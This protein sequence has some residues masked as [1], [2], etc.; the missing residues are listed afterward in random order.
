[1]SS[2]A[3]RLAA[4]R[5]DLV[6]LRRTLHRRPELSEE[7]HG[8]AALLADLLE[9][10]GVDVRTGVGGAGIVGRIRSPR[11]GPVLAL[12]G[13]MDALPIH[14][15]KDAPYR[16]EIDG[17]C[18][19]CGHDVH[20]TAIVGAARL[21][22]ER[23]EELPGDVVVLLQP[24][25]ELSRGARAMI[26][27][28]ALEGVDAILGLHAFPNL[29]AGTVGLRHGPMCAAAESFRI[30]VAGRSGHAARPH[31]GVDAILTASSVVGSI[32]HLVSRRVDPLAPAV[33]TL[34]TLRGG[35]ATNVIADRVDITGTVRTLDMDLLGRIRTQLQEVVH[36]ICLAS[37]AEFHFEV[38][39]TNPPLTNDGPTVGRLH[40]VLEA[41]LGPG[42]VVDLEDPSMG[43]EDF[44]FF[45]EAVPGTLVRLGTHGGTEATRH[46]LHHPLFDVDE[47]CIATAVRTLA[48]A[49]LAGIV[50]P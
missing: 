2:L 23:A 5:T 12:R 31:L 37:G 50:A 29:P 49:A 33:I 42:A 43:S 25:E 3:D 16:S 41:E 35:V 36:G 17:V 27:D 4:L 13:D 47:S 32:H 30:V 9:R 11:G 14:D 7:E 19:A 6:E 26:A 24:A 1:M 46:P 15:G 45:L 38:I 40:E 22:A 44:A 18:H 48:A 8:T 20:A 10:A 28:G 34:G 39:E 21:L